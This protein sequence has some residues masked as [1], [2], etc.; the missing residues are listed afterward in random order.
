MSPAFLPP[1]VFWA[2]PSGRR[3]RADPEEA[4]ETYFPSGQGTL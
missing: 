2:R 1:E 4:E 3:P